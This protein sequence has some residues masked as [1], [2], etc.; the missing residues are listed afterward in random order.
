MGEAVGRL[1][2]HL[3]TS[4]GF[5]LPMRKPDCHCRL[6][7]VVLET[8]ERLWYDLGPSLHPLLPEVF[9]PEKL[10]LH[11]L[12]RLSPWRSS[13]SLRKYPFSSL[14]SL[15]ECAARLG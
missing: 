7:Q 4:A 13:P 2:T 3:R 9:L 6:E 15:I 8:L 1:E 10:S 14:G 5:V 11:R 12:V